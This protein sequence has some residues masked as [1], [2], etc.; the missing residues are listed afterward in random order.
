MKLT[1]GICTK[2]RSQKLRQCLSSLKKQS[3]YIDQLIVLEDTSNQHN[4]SQLSLQK[5]L[6]DLKKTRVIYRSVRFSN[7]A[8]SRTKM[9]QMVQDGVLLSVDDDVVIGDN[10]IKKVKSFFD[11]KKDASLLIGR[12]FPINPNNPVSQVDYVYCSQGVLNFN[13][14]H[15]IKMCPFSF[16][17]LNI[18]QIKK[19]PTKVLNFDFR[20]PIGEDIDFSLRLFESQQKLFFD[21]TIINYNEYDTS[22]LLFL[23]KKFRH[24]KYLYKL[25]QKHQ[26]EYRDPATLPHSL[27]SLELPLFFWQE[28]WSMT[29]Y[30]FRIYDFSLL[31]KLIVFCGE[32]ATLLGMTTYKLSS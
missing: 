10:A 4:F 17:A 11:K 28:L 1:V 25:Y 15:R 23:S 26:E 20:F 7:I 16:V 2:D 31:E 3:Q 30:Y 22:L 19:Q 29:N 9:V 18:T 24:G 5:F 12:M 27:S 13:R 14:L 21:P 32:A 8:I 6:G